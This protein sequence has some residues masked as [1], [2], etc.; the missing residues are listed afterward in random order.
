MKY[1]ELKLSESDEPLVQISILESNRE[2][3][4]KE[5]LKLC[6]RIED[7]DFRIRCISTISTFL[8]YSDSL[9]FYPLMG[10]IMAEL[11]II[12]VRYNINTPYVTTCTSEDCDIFKAIQHCME[13]YKKY[14]NEMRYLQE[15]IAKQQTQG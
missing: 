3:Y 9:F 5:A 10:R 13:K 7:V 6:D 8:R 15:R 11:H 4:A 2:L 14:H 12:G 1:K